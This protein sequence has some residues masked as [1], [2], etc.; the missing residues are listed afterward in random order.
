MLEDQIF[1]REWHYYH[2]WS[3]LQDEI[4]R[5][6]QALEVQDEAEELDEAEEEKKD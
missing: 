6:L 1:E 4:N 3:N 5:K 2:S